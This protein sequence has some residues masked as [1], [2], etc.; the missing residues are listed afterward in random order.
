MKTTT[1]FISTN[2]SLTPALLRRAPTMIYLFGDNLE[3]W[4]YAGQALVRDEPNAIGIPTKKRPSME[5]GS[6]FTD[7]EYDANV[8]A[9]EAALGRIPSD[10]AAV[11]VPVN[12]GRGRAQLRQHA[13]KTY[14]YLRKRLG[15][16]G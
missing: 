8:A 9:I 4:G 15:L 13:P 6:F 16:L 11:F 10:A 7:A 5:R 12:I 3:G 14:E 1:K 2:E